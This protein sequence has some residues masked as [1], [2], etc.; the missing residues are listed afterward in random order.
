MPGDYV[1][2][3]CPDRSFS[4]PAHLASHR[5]WKHG[6]ASTPAGPSDA[7][8]ASGDD[9]AGGAYASEERRPSSPDGAEPMEEAK[10]PS[11]SDRLFGGKK[12]SSAGASSSP[13][14]TGE[15]RPVASNKK[16]ANATEFW[17]GGVEFAASLIG[18]AGYVPMARSMVWSS[19][20]AGEIIEDATKGTVV[21]KLVQPL[22]RNGEKWQDLFDLLGLWGAIGIAQANPAQEK[23][24]L[25]FARKRLI[26]ILPRIAANIRKQREI[27]RKAVEAVTELMP[28]LA[29]LFPDLQRDAGGNF[30]DDAG[31]RVDP[32]DLLLQTMF[33]APGMTEAQP[34]RI[35]DGATA[36][37]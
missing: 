33:A 17:G 14:P 24:A 20:V 22:V 27:E 25:T 19:P 31:R 30:I 9:G 5:K 37:V 1:C 21:D 16:R 12:K 32:V 36:P 6:D 26:N 28:D 4:M 23:A 11:L 3:D 29:D 18:R 15:R 2:P 10:Q 35:Q 13:A 7:G 8:T 34:E